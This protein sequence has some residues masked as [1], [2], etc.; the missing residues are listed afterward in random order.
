MKAKI[1]NKSELR[2]SDLTREYVFDIL[3]DSGE[4]VLA[5]QRITTRPST[6][7]TDVQEKVAEYEV[8]Y[9]DQNDVEVGQEI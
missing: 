8:A 7:V 2:L 1:T 3:D 9:E 4:I 5:N 6:V